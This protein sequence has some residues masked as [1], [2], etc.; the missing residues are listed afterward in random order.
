MNNIKKD[1][2]LNLIPQEKCYETPILR[3]NTSLRALRLLNTLTKLI[4]T[5]NI[6]EGKEKCTYAD[7]AAPVYKREA[8]RS[9]G[10]R[11]PTIRRRRL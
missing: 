3:I 6:K 9:S 8:P 5:L 10:P 7:F 2:Y 1:T 11:S 4:V